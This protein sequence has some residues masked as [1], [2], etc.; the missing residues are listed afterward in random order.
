MISRFKIMAQRA[1]LL[2]ERGTNLFRAA[3]NLEGRIPKDD[4]RFDYLKEIVD[5]YFE[6]IVVLYGVEDQIDEEIARLRGA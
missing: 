3:Q 1:R 4:P 6:G 5:R 2:R